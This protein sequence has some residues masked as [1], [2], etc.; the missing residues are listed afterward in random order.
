VAER[1]PAIEAEKRAA[2]WAAARLIRTGM[3]V[4]L[5]SGPTVACLVEVLAQARPDACFVAASPAT[6]AAAQQHGLPLVALDAVAGLDLAID[7]ADQ[8]DPSGW[9]IKGGGAAHTREKIIAAAARRFIVIASSNKLVERLRPPLPLELLPFAPAT[10][11]AAI[12]ST[13]RRAKMPVSPDGGVIAD[14]HGPID[15]PGQL[16][17]RLDEQPGVI[18]HGLFPPAMVDLVVVGRDYGGVEVFRPNRRPTV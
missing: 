16:A 6:A 8:I 13:R 5:G 11:M 18:A 3:T 10:T 9:L 1:S 17:R 4:G 15:D 14:Y 12:G 7:G 2:A